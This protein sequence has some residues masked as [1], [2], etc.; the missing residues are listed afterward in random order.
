MN[1]TQIKTNEVLKRGIELIGVSAEGYAASI[2]K[3]RATLYRYLKGDQPVPYEVL[4]NLLDLIYDHGIDIIRLLGIQDEDQYFY[5]ATGSNI[6]FPI[7]VHINDGEK[8]D[9]GHGF[10]MGENLRQSSTWG[11]LGYS[12]SI[13]RF[14][15]DKFVGLP[16]LD[17]NALKAID[18]LNYVAINRQKIKYQQYPSLFE[19]YR[20]MEKGKALI[21]GKIADSFSYEV[22]ELL[23]RDKLDVDQAEFSTKLMALGN[24]FCLKDDAFAKNLEADEVIR[25]DTTLSRYFLHYAEEVQQKQNKHIETLIKN[26]PKKDRLFSEYLK[27]YE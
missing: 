22:L 18:W 20:K 9:F 17:F 23:Y 19:K 13:Y 27:P 3:D 25:Y 14:K 2:G 5:H 8:R 6:R 15:R 1:E 24:Q 4:A 10:Y 21:K 11:K 7:D 16:I 26:P 12:T